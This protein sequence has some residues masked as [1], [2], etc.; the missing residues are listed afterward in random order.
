MGPFTRPSRFSVNHWNLGG[1]YTIEYMGE[2]LVGCS[3]ERKSYDFHTA[4]LRTA[5]RDEYIRRSVGEYAP[6]LS[7]AHVTLGRTYS[8][9][10]PKAWSHDDIGLFSFGPV[11]L[12]V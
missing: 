11:R 7:I 1:V 5:K 6:V 2:V 12:S 8:R 9:R 4:K 3:F 10:I